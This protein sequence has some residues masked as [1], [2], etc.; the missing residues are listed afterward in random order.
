M[1]EMVSKISMKPCD[2]FFFS[3]CL[4]S[5]KDLVKSL[6]AFSISDSYWNRDCKNPG[7]LFSFLWAFFWCFKFYS[8]FLLSSFIWLKRFLW[9]MEFFRVFICFLIISCILQSFLG[10]RNANN[11]FGLSINMSKMLSFLGTGLSSLR[12]IIE[13]SFSI[14]FIS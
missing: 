12:P 13:S 8:T 5:L 10:F 9:K 2:S 11:G 4:S 14:F 3:C 7:T 1:F 6:I